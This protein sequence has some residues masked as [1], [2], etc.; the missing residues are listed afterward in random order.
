MGHGRIACVG[1]TATG[2]ISCGCALELSRYPPGAGARRASRRAG[3]QGHSAA[4]GYRKRRSACRHRGCDG[5]RPGLEARGPPGRRRRVVHTR[6]AHRLS[7][8]QRARRDRPTAPPQRDGKAPNAR[9]PV[10]CRPAALV[11]KRPRPANGR[12]RTRVASACTSRRSATA[13]SPAPGSTTASPAAAGSERRAD[14]AGDRTKPDRC[15]TC[16][17]PRACG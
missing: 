6:Y 12:K 1:G 17:R 4:A 8:R 2:A 5:E 7:R 14:P 10:A 15:S 16:P 11:A 3:R 9:R 13:G